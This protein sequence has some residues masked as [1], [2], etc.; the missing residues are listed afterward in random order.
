MLAFAALRVCVAVRRALSRAVISLLLRHVWSAIESGSRTTRT[1]RLPRPAAMLV[2][3]V[4]YW[5][6][7]AAPPALAPPQSRLGMP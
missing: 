7:S 4:W 5:L 6:R 2:I 1:V 3:H